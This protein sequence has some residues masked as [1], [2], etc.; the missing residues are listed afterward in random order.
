MRRLAVLLGIAGVA[1]SFA[2][3]AYADPATDPKLDTNFLDALQRAGITFDNGAEAVN[4]AKGACDLI[5]QGR[6]QL[7][8]V[9]MVTEQ[10]PRIDTMT[11]AKFTAIAASAYCPQQLPRASASGG[12]QN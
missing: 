5:N 3:P 12:G 10:N 9:H 1:L 6:S 2:T 8:V 4:A 11:A 7:D